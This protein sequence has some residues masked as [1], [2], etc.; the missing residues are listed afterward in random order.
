MSEIYNFI[1][2]KWVQ[3]DKQPEEGPSLYWVEGWDSYMNDGHLHYGLSAN[4]Y[5]RD[6]YEYNEWQDGYE[7]AKED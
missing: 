4:P 7:A 3:I 6:T 2:G 1:T 5:P